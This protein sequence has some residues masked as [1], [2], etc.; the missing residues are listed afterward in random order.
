[1]SWLSNDAFKEI[2]DEVDKHLEKRLELER[3]NN[4]GWDLVSRQLVLEKLN[5][6]QATILKWEKCGLKSYQSPFE[7]SKKIYYRKCDI[8]NFLSVE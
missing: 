5:I 4:D 1:M 3:Q 2:L 7:N 6:S 8:Y